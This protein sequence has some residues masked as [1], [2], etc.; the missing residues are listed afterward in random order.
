MQ[1][2]LRTTFKQ[3]EEEGCCRYL[4]KKKA[5]SFTPTRD[6]I[7]DFILFFSYKRIIAWATVMGSLCH[8]VIVVTVVSGCYI[9]EKNGLFLRYFW[10]VAVK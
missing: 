3:R 2:A 4:F 9:L 10:D 8:G 5:D 7:D 1:S 6:L